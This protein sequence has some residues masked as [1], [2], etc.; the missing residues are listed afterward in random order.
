MRRQCEE[1]CAKVVSEGQRFAAATA[2]AAAQR[3]PAVP[4]QHAASFQ[5]PGCAAAEQSCNGSPTN[6]HRQR[7]SVA[8][9]MSSRSVSDPSVDE[10]VCRNGADLW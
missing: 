2:A 3:S 9:P 4:V 5:T 10:S 6:H 7:A 1:R 8:D